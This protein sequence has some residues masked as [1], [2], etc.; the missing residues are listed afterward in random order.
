MIGFLVAATYAALRLA[1]T[2]A[3]PET[4]F[5]EASRLLFGWYLTTGLLTVATA[6]LVW[7]GDFGSEGARMRHGV[8]TPLAWA[9]GLARVPMASLAPLMALAVRRLLLGVGAFWWM[10]G[11]RAM[12]AEFVR[13]EPTLVMGA[14]AL[15]IGLLLG[16]LCWP[17]RRM[18]DAPQLSS[19]PPSLHQDPF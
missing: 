6:T 15:G 13:D 10:Q 5:I 8:A 12:G 19:E 14:V 2:P 1:L 16:L 18:A 3:L 4:V 11:L 9:L 7:A 17:M